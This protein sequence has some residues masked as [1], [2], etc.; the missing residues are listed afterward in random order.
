MGDEKTVVR[1]RV[2]VRPVCEGAGAGSGGGHHRLLSGGVVTTGST[3][4]YSS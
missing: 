4:V 2:S 1:P 3:A